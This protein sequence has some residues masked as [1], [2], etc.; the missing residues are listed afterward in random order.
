MV[1]YPLDLTNDGIEEIGILYGP[2]VGSGKNGRASMLFVKDKQGHY[3]LNID[4]PG[5][6]YFINFGSIVFPDVLVINNVI[7]LPVYR[8]DGN[9][10]NEH[11]LLKRSDLK[12]LNTTAMPSAS[13]RYTSTLVRE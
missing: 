11:K 7:Q 4:V 12:R 5:E 10:Y 3:Q 1:V 13:S 9:V 6:F 2:K 8:W